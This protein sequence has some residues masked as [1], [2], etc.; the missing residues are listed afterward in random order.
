LQDITPELADRFQ[1]K[2]THGALVSDI[3][4][5]SPAKKAGFQDGDVVIR[6]N[7]KEILNGNQLMFAVAETK[8]G[9]TVPVTILRSGDEKN[10]KV[11]IKS[12]PGKEETAENNS[13]ANTDSGTLNG[14]GVADLDS[15]V[16]SQLHIPENVT[17]AVITEVDPASAAA[18]AGLKPGDVIQ[19]INHHAVKS[20]NAAVE[21]TANPATKKTLLRIWSGGGS[22]YVVVDESKAN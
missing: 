9:T 20:A 3:T 12:I 18:D 16:R 6:Y 19:E 15:Q 22:R 2:N 1:L 4:G 5:D 11:T 13:N 10:L 8:P 7:G 17:G 14:V 21:L